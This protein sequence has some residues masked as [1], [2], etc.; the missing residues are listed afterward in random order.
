MI[1]KSNMTD[2]MLPTGI[3]TYEFWSEKSLYTLIYLLD[4][5]IRK[6][7]KKKLNNVLCFASVWLKNSLHKQKNCDAIQNVIKTF[8]SNSSKENSL[9]TN[10]PITFL[11]TW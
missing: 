4:Y 3:L 11:Y 7:K 10:D 9:K 5:R 2:R 1:V 8:K 6:K